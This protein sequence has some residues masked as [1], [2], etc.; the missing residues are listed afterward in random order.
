MSACRRMLDNMHVR[1]RTV[2][3]TEEVHGS[4][5]N[6]SAWISNNFSFGS[7]HFQFRL[8]GR[9]QDTCLVISGGRIRAAF[10][11]PELNEIPCERESERGREGEGL[12]LM[13]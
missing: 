2:Y 4:V 5:H 10:T 11:H 13:V 6:L 3:V 7:G 9:A 12:A 1:M 8:S